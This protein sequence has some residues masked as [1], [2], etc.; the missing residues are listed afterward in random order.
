MHVLV[1]FLAQGYDKSGIPGTATGPL[2]HA[3]TWCKGIDDLEK[4]CAEAYAKGARFAKWR[5]VLQIDT[6]QGLPSDLGIE[7]SGKITMFLKTCVF[8]FRKHAFS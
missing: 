5:N 8:C 2:G 7:V 6:A 1:S 4:R 3:E